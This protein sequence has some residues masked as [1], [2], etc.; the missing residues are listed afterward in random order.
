M[1]LHWMVV[2]KEK[3]SALL[4]SN[5]TA[6]SGITIQTLTRASNLKAK[7]MPDSH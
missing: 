2:K 1:P 6:S 5:K 7:R 3:L 4:K